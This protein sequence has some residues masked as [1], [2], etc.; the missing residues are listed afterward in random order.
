MKGETLPS[1][2]ADD[3]SCYTATATQEAF[4]VLF[5]SDYDKSKILES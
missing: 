1:V 5:A 4:M 2:S 3:P